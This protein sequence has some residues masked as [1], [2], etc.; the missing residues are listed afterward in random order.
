MRKMMLCAVVGLLMVAQSALAT[1]SVT[2][3]APTPPGFLKDAGQAFHLRIV[4]GPEGGVHVGSD[5][6]KEKTVFSGPI[7]FVHAQSGESVAF[8]ASKAF[9]YAVN[10]KGDVRPFFALKNYSELRSDVSVVIS[11]RLELH[12]SIK[13]EKVNQLATEHYVV[14]VR[15][16]S[17]EVSVFSVWTDSNIGFGV[18]KHA[19]PHSKG[20]LVS[21][22]QT[23]LE[24]PRFRTFGEEESLFIEMT[25]NFSQGGWQKRPL[26][27]APSGSDR[28]VPQFGSTQGFPKVS[29]KWNPNRVD[30]LIEE[31]LKA[32]KRNL[33]G[34]QTY[35]ANSPAELETLSQAQL[36]REYLGYIL[37]TESGTD[38]AKLRTVIRTAFEV[39]EIQLLGN[40]SEEVLFLD[41]F[42]TP[43]LAESFNPTYLR[44]MASK[45][46]PFCGV[47]AA[48][49]KY[50]TELW[51]LKTP[52]KISLVR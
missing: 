18:S 48:N 31:E 10:F 11:N 20:Q 46:T 34:T 2:L 36:L 26:I 51:S 43:T 19:F 8:F 4:Q 22:S 14:A 41:L 42:P 33:I 50:L 25:V 38:E 37:A 9:L 40:Y 47:A 39:G 45:F 21:V 27:F 32:H 28:I 3:R 49:G 17:G 24:G 5:A 44:R 1:L 35:G 7:E 15:E 52:S 30:A 12:S 13:N 6:E 23:V 29:P 16:A